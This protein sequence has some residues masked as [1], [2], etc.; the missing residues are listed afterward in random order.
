MVMSGKECDV[1]LFSSWVDTTKYPSLLTHFLILVIQWS[2]GDNRQGD[3]GY[4]LSAESGTCISE[5]LIELT[6]ALVP[7]VSSLEILVLLFDTISRY[8]KYNFKGMLSIIF[9]V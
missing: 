7:L 9:K 8:V 5:I 6:V 4:S 3:S 1:S 2:K